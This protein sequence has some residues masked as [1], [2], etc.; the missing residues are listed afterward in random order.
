M[1]CT[2]Y[3][4]VETCIGCISHKPQT[5]AG[6]QFFEFLDN[7]VS[8]VSWRLIRK[9]NRPLSKCSAR[10]TVLNEAGLLGQAFACNAKDNK[11]MG[12]PNS[13][14]RLIAKNL[15]ILLVENDCP[16]RLDN[17]LRLGQ[18][19]NKKGELRPEWYVKKVMI[20]RNKRTALRRF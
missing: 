18:S 15:T 10:L 9:I 7:G 17:G 4:T 2:L 14:E 19:S 5:A 16:D 6:N 20:R 13:P 8:R 12:R 1:R 3:S 11:E